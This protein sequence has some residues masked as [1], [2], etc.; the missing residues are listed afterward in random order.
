MLIGQQ[1]LGETEAA[2]E[3]LYVW[4]DEDRFQHYAA[5]YCLLLAAGAIYGMAG[6]LKRLEQIGQHLLQ[7]GLAKEHPLSITWAS[8]FL[9][10]AHYH[11]NRLEEA[12]AH[13]STVAKWPYQ[14]NFLVYQDAMLGLVLVYHSQ[15]D[16]TK[17]RQTL[18][19][20]TQ[21]MLEINQIQ[22]TAQVESF[23][24]RLA[25]L[26]G[27]VDTAVHWLQTG[28]KPTWRSL[29]FWEANDMTRIKALI[30]QGTAISHQEAEDL[31][32]SSQQFAEGT[33]N[34][35]LLIQIWALRALLAQA[36][37][38]QEAALDAVKH[39]VHL[40][41]PGGYLR[42]FVEMGAEMA[43][44]LTQLAASG[45]APAYIDRILAV[46]RADQL[47]EEDALTSRELEI[48]ALL[49]KGL[50]DKEIAERLVLS[51]LTVKKHNRNIYQ[52]LGVNGRRQA[53]AKAKILNLL[54]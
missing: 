6:D 53:A 38:K 16:E 43:D 40:A 5:R 2:L 37:G 3:K 8:H 45:V 15:G 23:R 39:A 52:K 31:L 20:L 28:L 34:V 1:S 51:L 41:E 18:D 10:H 49:Q 42:I 19:T 48:L 26:C 11:W 17:A 27:D 30:A 9:G 33:A 29:W 13:W 12:A 47:L 14:A 32:T 24:T 35:W 36:W 46:F 21:V 4:L 7:A 25:L 50:S 22:S 54:P 44:L